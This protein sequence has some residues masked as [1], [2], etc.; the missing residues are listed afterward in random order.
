MSTV[1][2][3]WF[4]ERL[5]ERG[6]SQRALA[7]FLN[8]DPASVSL[9]LRGQREMRM[10]EAA[11]LSR[12]LGQPINEVLLNA[13]IVD[14]MPAR[15]SMEVPLVGHIDAAT[16]EFRR[17]HD[18]SD[19]DVPT[20]PC[21]NHDDLAGELV[22]ARVRAL[23]VTVLGDFFGGWTMYFRPAHNV[24]SEA[25]DRLS[26][27]QLSPSGPMLLRHV[28]RGYGRGLY[29]LMSRTLK[30]IENVRLEWASPVVWINCL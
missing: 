6:R 17:D 1:N 3:R 18:P 20:V 29:N 27:V 8:L 12:F 4:R 13:G 7:E 25:I 22:A 14:A 9:M 5:A 15:S 2:T 23:D 28:K 21:P 30:P 16:L 10:N 26:F 19:P 11:R 24:D